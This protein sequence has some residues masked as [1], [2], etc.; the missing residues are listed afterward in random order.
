MKT[1]TTLG[2]VSVLFLGLIT[3]ASASIDKNLKYGQRDK[4]VTE[5]Q[6]F[7]IDGGFLK[8]LPTAFFG[9]LT[10]KAVK[11][12]Q[13]S[14]DISPTG[15]VGILTRQKINDSILSD[16]ASSTQAEIQETGTTTALTLDSGCSSTFG[17]NTITGKS[18][19]ISIMTPNIITQVFD[20]CKNIEGI[21]TSV[22]VSMLADSSGNC[23]IQYQQ[24]NYVTPP[25]VP[26][27]INSQPI[28]QPTTNTTV[29]SVTV[30]ADPN[31]TS[32]RVTG[33]ATNVPVGQFTMKAYGEDVKVKSLQ[34]AFTQGTVTTL[35]W[36]S[37][38]VNGAQV[39]TS[40]NYTGSNL[41]YALGSSLIVPA[42]QT[43]ILTVKADIVDSNNIAYRTGSIV[44]VIGGVD[45]NAQGLTSGQIITV[46]TPTIVGQLMTISTFS[47]I[48]IN[49]PDFRALS[50][51]SNSN[52]IKIGSFTFQSPSCCQ[53]VAN[54]VVVNFTYGGNPAMMP[55]NISNLI[56]KVDS[57]VFS[58]TLND[59]VATFPYLDFNI[60]ENTTMVFDLYAD[61]GS[62]T[63]TI[64]TN[65][66]F[67]TRHA[68]S[69][70]HQESLSDGVVISVISAQ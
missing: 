53:V 15:Y 34:V 36:V 2:V 65:M 51:N 38:Y 28:V 30:I 62:S 43:V 55:S 1:I 59:N 58:G 13:K 52:N 39:G 40:Q 19:S 54:G 48:L 50:I 11:S 22:P 67:N 69:G 41:N 63:G 60:P 14:V 23:F 8:G 57:K 6:E 18:C 32:N 12:Y 42:G 35:G 31:F 47:S 27:T 45:N 7:L 44:A 49:T 46:G 66:K 61:I 21:Q 37:L 33:G 16:L 25:I 17:F 24:N 56:L 68:I 20:V 3:S 9:L 64:K 26:S 70:T 29:G 4:E 5:L 10:L